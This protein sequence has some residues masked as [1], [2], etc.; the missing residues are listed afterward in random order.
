M[1]CKDFF[2]ISIYLK[3]AFKHLATI[4]H[5]K[6]EKDL[7]NYFFPYLNCLKEKFSAKKSQRHDIEVYYRN[8]G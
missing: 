1:Y 5:G 4:M 7:Q 8:L 6:F 3:F 2:F